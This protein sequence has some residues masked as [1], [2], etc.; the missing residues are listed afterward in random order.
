MDPTPPVLVLLSVLVHD[1]L[2]RERVFDGPQ[3]LTSWGSGPPLCFSFLSVVHAMKGMP[4]Y[5][6]RT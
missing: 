5:V 4:R 1:R 3:H 6:N 2:L